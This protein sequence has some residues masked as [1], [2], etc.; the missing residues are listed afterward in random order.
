M[1]FYANTVL[2]VHVLNKDKKERKIKR[3]RI[4][5]VLT[6]ARSLQVIPKE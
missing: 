1:Y 4:N 5:K 2:N 3:K 6:L